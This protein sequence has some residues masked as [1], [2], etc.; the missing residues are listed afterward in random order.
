MPYLLN[1]LPI[2]FLFFY[3][4]VSAQKSNIDDTLRYQYSVIDTPYGDYFGWITLKRDGRSYQG[5]LID[6]DGSSHGLQVIK[7]DN[8]HLIFK[9]KFEANKTLFKCEI[10]GDSIRGLGKFPGEKFEFLLKG[11]RV[12]D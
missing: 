9:L 11:R 6:E 12:K 10:F 7:Y 2:P 8:R 4:V 5:K 1:F 3:G